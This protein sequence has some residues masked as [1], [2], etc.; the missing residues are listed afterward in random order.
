M[1][2]NLIAAAT[3]SGSTVG[4]FAALN[5]AKEKLVLTSAAAEAARDAHYFNIGTKTLLLEGARM[6]DFQRSEELDNAYWT[7]FQ[8]SI[9][10]N[11]VAAP[12]G[13]VTADKLVEDST[14]SSIH[15]IQRATPSLTDNTKSAVSFFAKAAERSWLLVEIRDKGN[16]L[17]NSFFDI[18]NG[19]LGTIDAE[20]TARISKE[21]EDG[22]YRCEIVFDAA[23]GGTGPTVTLM[24]ATGDLGET[25]SGDG[26]SGAYLWGLQFE[27]DK[28]F[29]SS[30]IKTTTAAVT[31]V[32][33]QISWP[34]TLIPQ[35]MTI[36][37]V[38]VELG[39]FLRASVE[40]TSFYYC[41]IGDDGSLED[42][43]LVDAN[44][45]NIRV[46]YQNNTVVNSTIGSPDPKIG[47]LVELRAVLFPDGAVQIHDSINGAAEVS[48]PKSAALALPLA[49]GN[50]KIWL[51]RPQDG[52]CAF[53]SVKVALG[54]QTRDF[55]RKF[56]D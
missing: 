22:W 44:N 25:Y 32:A 46:R 41:Y 14:A 1:S 37:L 40:A 49:W 27:T 12:D 9:T 3:F 20:H 36:Y 6:N 45:G 7:K 21:F 15:Y 55:M 53:H 54:V 51:N 29:A 11:A 13:L 5:S 10:A 24:L 35:A 56:A 42:S 30:Y 17:K 16:N 33:D 23:S 50:T 8:S 19:A 34:F 47:D 18:G 31:R 48:G 43:I 2:H 4:M 26:A 52:F 38:L 28:P 39:T